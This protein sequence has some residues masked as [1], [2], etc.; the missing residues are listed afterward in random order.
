M[1][2]SGVV[3]ALACFLV[4]SAVL[5]PHAEAAVTCGSVATAVAPCLGYLRGTGG[6]PPAGCCSSI[7]GL[8]A[9]AKTPAE[10]KTACNCLKSAAGSISGLNYGLA[11]RLPAACGVNI[12]YKIS[13]ST[14]CNQVQ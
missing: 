2:S 12:P 14:N 13:P 4:A 7:R 6:A 9:A 10:R 8:N 11:A 5:A 3:R 1:A